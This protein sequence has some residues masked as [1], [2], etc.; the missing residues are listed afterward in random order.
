MFAA[1][2]LPA[3]PTTPLPWGE[4]QATVAG[5]SNGGL[6]LI[7][8]SLLS[9]LAPAWERWARWLLDRRELLRIA[10]AGDL[11]RGDRVG[12]FAEGDEAP[13]APPVGGEQAGV[14]AEYP[15]NG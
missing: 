2:G 12:E 1:A 3:P 9:V 6:Y 11:Q 15:D 7:P 4:N 10:L 5:N 14:E 8:A 13:R